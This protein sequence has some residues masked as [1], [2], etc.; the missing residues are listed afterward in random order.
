MVGK[1]PQKNNQRHT[2]NNDEDTLHVDVGAEN[3]KAVVDKDRQG[4]LKSDKTQISK[5][6]QYSQSDAKGSDHLRKCLAA[7]A[8]QHEPVHQRTGQSRNEDGYNSCQQKREIQKIQQHPAQI[9]G[10]D[11]QG[12]IGK[13]CHAADAER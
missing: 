13:I 6:F 5:Q 7:Y 3:N 10:H 11:I 4:V 2:D 1:E 12:T 8:Q 9:G